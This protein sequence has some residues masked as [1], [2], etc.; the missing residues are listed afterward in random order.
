MLAN[1]TIFSLISQVTIHNINES[2]FIRNQT[3][4]IPDD[5]EITKITV[6]RN[7]NYFPM[8]STSNIDFDENMMSEK[9]SKSMRL[10]DPRLVG[11]ELA[12]TSNILKPKTTIR[13][14]GG[15]F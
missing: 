11:G 14:F 6:P 12:G 8:S 7:Q 15:N 9:F 4:Q 5:I 2:K 1:P 13:E 3:Q 10:N